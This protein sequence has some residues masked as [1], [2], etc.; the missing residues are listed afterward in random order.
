MGAQHGL[1]RLGLLPSSIVR[2]YWAEYFPAAIPAFAQ[3][4]LTLGKGFG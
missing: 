3:A 4:W 1:H 2:C